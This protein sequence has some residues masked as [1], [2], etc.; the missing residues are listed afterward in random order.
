MIVLSTMYTQGESMWGQA[1]FG[2]VASVFSLFNM[3]LCKDATLSLL[4][5]LSAKFDKSRGKG[6][7][8]QSDRSLST[9]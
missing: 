9:G 2:V 4:K 7:N 5:W 1:G 8:H 3:M 6:R